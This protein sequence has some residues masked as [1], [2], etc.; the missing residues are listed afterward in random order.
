MTVWVGRLILANVAMLLVSLALPGLMQGLALVPALV[1]SRP[2][3]LVTYMFLHAGLDHLFFNMLSLF[4]F[5][6]RL[7]ERL[8]P[9]A[10]LKLYFASGLV[11]ALLSVVRP[12][13]PF[14]PIVGASGAVFGVMLGFAR[15]WPRERIFIWGILG[16]EARVFVVIMTVLSLLGAKSGAGNVAHLAHLGGFVGGFLY[17][18]WLEYR[19]PAAEWRRKVTPA[20]SIRTSSAKLEKWKAVRV[21]E[22]HPVNREEYDRVMAKLSEAGVGSLTPGEREFLDR[23]S[24]R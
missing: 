8:G 24:S 7:E 9:R 11:G 5:G 17:L 15:Y 18:K 14:V 21:E 6:P 1:P 23:F 3:T 19:S 16:V 20:A 13:Y 4:F 12:M 22:L 10:F 2:W